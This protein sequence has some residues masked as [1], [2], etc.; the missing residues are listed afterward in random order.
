MP[1]LHLKLLIEPLA[2]P[3]ERARAVAPKGRK[4]FATMYPDPKWGSDAKPAWKQDCQE[5]M[6]Y[7]LKDPENVEALK[8]LFDR[9]VKVRVQFVCTRPPTTKLEVPAPD[10]DNM[11]KAVL[12]AGNGVLWADDRQITDI[13]ASKRWAQVNWP[14]Y[15]FVEVEQAW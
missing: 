13:V 10:L 14:P 2:K 6:S 15:I 3:R 7:D 1:T 12:D 11:I 5:A 4:P 8:Y 9:L